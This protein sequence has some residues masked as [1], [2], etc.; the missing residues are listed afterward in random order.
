MGS[1]LAAPATGDPIGDG[2]TLEGSAKWSALIQRLPRRM[3]NAIAGVAGEIARYWQDRQD[4]P[5]PEQA[6]RLEA[7]L[8]RLEAAA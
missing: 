8:K 2:E 7:E 6:R 5:T 3:E 4:L 1:L